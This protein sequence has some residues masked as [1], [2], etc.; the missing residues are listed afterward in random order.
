MT[1]ETPCCA[2]WPDAH[3]PDCANAARD[4]QEHARRDLAPKM[5]MSAYVM[6]ISPGAEIDP[7]LALE[8]GVAVLLGKPIL[9]VSWP[10]RPPPAGLLRIAHRHIELTAPLTSLGGQ[11]QLPGRHARNLR[12][13]GDALMTPEFWTGF[14]FTNGA[15]LAVSLFLLV[16]G[17]IGGLI[18]WLGRR[19]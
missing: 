15:I 13:R 6:T 9:L 1:A 18:D 12:G 19:R 4:W 2:R 5:A 10:G 17:L 3:A 8:V 16:A 7:K 11:A 14:H